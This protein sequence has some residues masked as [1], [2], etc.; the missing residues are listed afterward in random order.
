MLRERL[1]EFELSP[2]V[3]YSPEE[4]E[5]AAQAEQES[6]DGYLVYLTALWSG[7]GAFYARNARPTVV[8]DE[9]YSGSG[10]LLRVSSMVV[11]ERLPVVTVASSDS[12]DVVDAVRLFEVMKEMREARILVVA[13]GES[14]GA[15]QGIVARTRELLGTEVTQIDSAALRAYYERVDP[16]EA[17][18]WKDKWIREALKVVEPPEDE[19]L[20]SHSEDGKGASV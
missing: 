15:R 1:P 20:R 10:G 9:L 8:A 14:W 7:I 18:V 6:Y 12:Q 19:I 3:F 2:A 17:V 4:A 5:R 11:A 16:D 13:D